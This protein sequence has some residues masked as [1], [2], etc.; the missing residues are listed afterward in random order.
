[1]IKLKKIITEQIEVDD[2]ASVDDVIEDPTITPA[3]SDKKV[4]ETDPTDTQSGHPHYMGT[5]KRAQKWVDESI[6]SLLPKGSQKRNGKTTANGNISDH[7]DGNAIAYAI[8]LPVKNWKTAE[9][10]ELGDIAWK[11]LRDW[12][13]SQCQLNISIAP[14]WLLDRNAK[15][16][17]NPSNDTSTAAAGNGAWI[18]FFDPHEPYRYQLGWNT[19]GHYNHIHIG[20]LFTKKA[21][22]GPVPVTTPSPR[23]D[24]D[25]EDD[26]DFWD[27][28]W[29]DSD[30]DSTEDEAVDS[31]PDDLKIK[32][33]TELE[34]WD[35]K[36]VELIKYYAR[37]FNIRVLTTDLLVI[38]DI[39]SSGDA[40]LRNDVTN[41]FGLFQLLKNGHHSNTESITKTM[42]IYNNIK[43]SVSYIKE[44][45]S[46][47]I[48]LLDKSDLKYLNVW[49]YLLHKYGIKQTEVLY[50]MYKKEDD[51]DLNFT[52]AQE[53]TKKQLE[54]FIDID[55]IDKYIESLKQRVK[56]SKID[57][58]WIK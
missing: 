16:F 30:E 28:L 31:V 10:K 23:Y 19:E 6:G 1:L 14:D 48:K 9:G 54:R 24:A 57:K 7:W 5:A 8:D 17:D 42:D 35:K 55:T 46:D 51:L 26:K 41:K 44:H 33:I 52:P 2:V 12:A 32:D 20:V 39:S 15:W 49:L 34:K 45:I 4:I 18:N 53:Q 25:E 22:S 40:T 38:A 27:R 21:G 13:L 56:K 47:L 11:K 50:K 36:I 43:Q 29:S 3:E 58:K 37:T